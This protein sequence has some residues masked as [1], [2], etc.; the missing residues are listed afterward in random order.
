MSILVTGG[1]GFIGSHI[2]DELILNNEDVIVA[3]N[4]SSGKIKNVNKKAA[5]CC[6]FKIISGLF[7]QRLF[8]SLYFCRRCFFR[9]VD[10]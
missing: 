8:Q 9:S 10:R 5:I 7:C 1:A 4:F 2:A 6:F 3:D